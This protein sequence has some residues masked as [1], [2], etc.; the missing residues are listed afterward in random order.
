MP[1]LK[2]GDTVFVLTG[3][4]RGKK[5]KILQIVREG[6]AAIVERINLM[7]H[8][9]RRT[10]QDQPGGIID[11]ETPLALAKLALACPRCNKPT[12]VGMRISGGGAKQRIC[13]RCQ[14]AFGG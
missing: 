13:K 4:D 14:E 9:E 7:K 1:R 8:F 12:R 3:K 6:E 2:K 10:R 5:G 11:R